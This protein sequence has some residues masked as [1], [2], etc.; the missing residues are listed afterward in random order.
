MTKLRRIHLTEVCE[1][2][3]AC[4]VV[5]LVDYIMHLLNIVQ[6]LTSTNG[7]SSFYNS[8]PVIIEKKDGDGFAGKNLTSI[9]VGLSPA[10]L[11]TPCRLP[12]A[13][14]PLFDLCRDDDEDDDEDDDDEDDDDDDYDDNCDDDGDDD[15]DNCDNYDDYDHGP[16]ANC[17][18]SAF[19]I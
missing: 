2:E 18:I 19:L 4:S 9:S 15:D 16:P 13:T 1:W 5:Y 6:L 17:L 11:I 3:G 8:T 7:L 10:L 12:W 14:R